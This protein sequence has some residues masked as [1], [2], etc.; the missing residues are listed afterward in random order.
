[1][2]TNSGESCRLESS[3]SSGAPKS[4]PHS[5]GT[6][7][8]R[9]SAID[10]FQLLATAVEHAAD[11]GH[12]QPLLER[13]HVVERGPRPLR[14]HHPE[15]DQVTARLALLGPERGTQ[16]VDAPERHRRGLHVQLTALGE[17]R[18]V[19]E[20]LGLEQRRRALAGTRGENGCIDQREPFAVHELA[21]RRHDLRA[22]A[23]DR[24]LARRSEPEVAVVHEEIH[25][26]LLGRDRV[27]ARERHHL[28]A[29]KPQLD[30][31]HLACVRFDRA[32]RD[33]R[34]LLRQRAARP[35]LFG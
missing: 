6:P 14:L 29:R 17:V 1:L 8:S 2:V 10:H 25:P 23:E 5:N 7:F 19:V 18:L 11:R 27:V 26:V 16:A 12:E 28:E 32:A 13:D 35:P 22:H 33:H 9:S 34:R 15:L 4:L 31:A 3:V 24:L 20:V 30:A 21:E